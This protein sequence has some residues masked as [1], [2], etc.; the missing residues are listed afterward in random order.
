MIALHAFGADHLW[1]NA[2]MFIVLG[3]FVFLG[4]VAVR[5][6]LQ[7]YTPEN[8]KPGPEPS[9]DERRT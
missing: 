2:P 7:N 8:E 1:S 5:T 6:K 9:D 3:L 4:A